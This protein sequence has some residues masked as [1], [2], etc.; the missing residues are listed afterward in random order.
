MKKD[1]LDIEK[2]L[3]EIAVR[4]ETFECPDYLTKKI[5]NLIDKGCPEQIDYK[6]KLNSL[7]KNIMDGIFKM[8]NVP[9]YDTVSC[10]QP[11][12]A[13]S[14]VKEMVPVSTKFAKPPFKYFLLKA[15]GDSMNEAGINNGDTVLI[16]Q[17][18]AANNGDKVVALID[19][20]AT[21]KEFYR[22]GEKIVLKPK[23]TNKAHQPIIL[24]RDFKIQGVVVEDFSSKE[25]LCIN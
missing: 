1:E 14:D 25:D 5:L 8:V 16:R 7:S 3:N 19:D 18:S 12:L 20:E 23:S 13:V 11:S 22:E 10:G 21:I 24:T 17:Q 15:K 6:A 4:A 2:V 9:L